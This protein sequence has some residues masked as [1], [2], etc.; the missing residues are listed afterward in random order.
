MLTGTNRNQ[1]VLSWPAGGSPAATPVVGVGTTGQ[2]DEAFAG[3][4]FAGTALEL[5]AEQRARLDSAV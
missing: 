5:T 3:T 2:L 4:A 1:V